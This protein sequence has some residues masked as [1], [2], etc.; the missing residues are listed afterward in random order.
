MTAIQVAYGLP[1]VSVIVSANGKD[2]E[3]DRV[4]LDTGSAATIFK[5]DD[6][7]QLDVLLSLT[8]EITFMRGVGGREPVVEKRVDSIAFG[9]LVISPMTIQIGALDYGFPINGILGLDFLL[10]TGAQINFSTLEIGK[11]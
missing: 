4:L 6:I 10:Q 11:A 2:I 3:I 1:F 7:E 5:T 9:D 8:D